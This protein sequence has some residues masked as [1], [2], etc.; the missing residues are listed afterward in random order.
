MS[1]HLFVAFLLGA[2]VYHALADQTPFGIVHGPKAAFN[3]AAPAGWVIDNTAGADDGLPCVLF[4]KGS[5]WEKANPLMYTKIAGTSFED[6]E[7]FA[8]RAIEE[9]KKERGEYQTKRVESGKTKSG[10]SYF[11][12]EY[13]PNEKYPR[14]ERVAYVQLPKA[15]AFVVYSADGEKAFRKHQPALKELL[16]S[17]TYMEAKGEGAE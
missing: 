17:F 4:R 9:M 7:A 3:I 13:S 10:Q 1:K 11:I 6:A 15:V 2:F 16:A 14:F 12:N 5:S 8:Q